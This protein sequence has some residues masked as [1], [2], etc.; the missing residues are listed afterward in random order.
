[1]TASLHA[2]H[3]DISVCTKTALPLTCNVRTARDHESIH[4]PPLVAAR[5]PGF[6]FATCAM[7][8]GEFLATI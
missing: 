6:A 4:A 3:P 5:S 7:D 2:E 8:K 1:M